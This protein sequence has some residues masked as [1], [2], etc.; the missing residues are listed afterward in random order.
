M[1]MAGPR[2]VDVHSPTKAT[3]AG[4]MVTLPAFDK[5][6]TEVHRNDQLQYEHAFKEAHKNVTLP[7]QRIFGG[8][9]RS[10]QNK[11]GGDLKH[12]WRQ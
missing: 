9:S 10:N 2:P 4:G 1:F 3:N 6:A 8:L 12:I 5:L 7:I 11:A